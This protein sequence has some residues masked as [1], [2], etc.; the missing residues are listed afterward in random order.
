M[1]C[2]K[3]PQKIHLLFDEIAEYYDKTNNYISFWTHNFVKYLA[4][5]KLNIKKYS[6]VID[7]C[8]GTGDINKIINKISPKTKVLNLDIS[9]NMLKLA[10]DKNPNGVFIQGDCTSLA[11]KDEEFDYITMSFGLRNVENRT[12]ALSEI[13]RTL[14]KDGKFLHIDFGYHNFI[15]KIFDIIALTIVKITGKNI[16]SYKYLIESKSEFPE[17]DSLIQEFEK[18]GL[19]Y[20]KKCD[21]LFGVISAQIMQK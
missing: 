9:T 20:I 12:K 11:F 17:P 15:S 18:A 6:T 2:N 5:K 4:I 1:T 19:K 3:T 10:K 21:Y 14:K 16:D 8:C 7:L 13:S